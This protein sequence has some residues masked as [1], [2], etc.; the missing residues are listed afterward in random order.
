M[1][2]MAN[3]L[4]RY[5]QEYRQK[6]SFS[7]LVISDSVCIYLK[8]IIKSY[9]AFLSSVMYVR[10]Q[11]RH[12]GSYCCYKE[13]ATRADRW[14]RK[15]FQKISFSLAASSEWVILFNVLDSHKNLK[16]RISSRGEEQDIQ[17]ITR[18]SKHKVALLDSDNKLSVIA[19]LRYLYMRS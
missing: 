11:H 3:L 17:N 12:H 16:L 9:F 4:C 8:C 7:D 19:K 14:N 5:I 1:A 10:A 18:I 2:I 6:I 15:H 13:K